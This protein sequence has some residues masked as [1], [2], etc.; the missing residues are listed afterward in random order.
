MTGRLRTRWPLA[1][2]LA[3]IAA[4]ALLVACGDGEDNA[5]AIEVSNAR[6][7]FTTTDVGAVYLDIRSTGADDRLV[8]ASADLAAEV[9]VHEVV[10]EGGSSRMRPVAD[11]IAVAAGGSVSLEPGGYHLM[12][13]GVAEVPEPGDTFTLTLRFERA[14]RVA[15]TVTVEAF[16]E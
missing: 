8:A 14:G 11:G 7:R 3:L 13:L 1:A 5:S 6:A 16:G 15:V 4:S 12:L 10:R 9:Q 2:A